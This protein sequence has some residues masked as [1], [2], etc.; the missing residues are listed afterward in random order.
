MFNRLGDHAT[1]EA[2]STWVQNQSYTKKKTNDLRDHLDKKRGG[3]HARLGT[4]PAKSQ[5]KNFEGL[6]RSFKETDRKRDTQDNTAIEDAP[7][8]AK[9][10]N[11]GSYVSE[12]Q[13]YLKRHRD[14]LKEKHKHIKISVIDCLGENS[15]P[16]QRSV[17][18]CNHL[19]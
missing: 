4:N 8:Q 3:V 2:N 11:H 18:L 1:N 15:E 9:P 10:F 16:H 5:S 19:F 17:D 14:N 12:H 7:E 13:V 6:D